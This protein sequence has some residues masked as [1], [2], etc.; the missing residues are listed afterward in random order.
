MLAARA[1]FLAIA[2]CALVPQTAFATTTSLEVFASWGNSSPGIRRNTSGTGPVVDTAADVSGGDLATASAS[3]DA[4]GLHV[5]ATAT[6][7]TPFFTAQASASAGLVNSFTIVPRAGFGGTH[8]LVRVPYSFSGSFLSHPSLAACAT[9]F[10]AV[11][12]RLSVDG[13][14][15][16]FYFVGAHSQGTMGNANF[17]AGGVAQAGMIEGLLPVNTPL[18]LRASLT[19][20]VHCQ[21]NTAS[22]CGIEALFGGALSYTGFSPD[23][24]DIVWGLVPTL[25]PEPASSALLAL[26][27]LGLGVAGC[28]AR[29]RR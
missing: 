13:L 14:G 12:V 20:N 17:I 1:G 22:S 5:V 28:F 25:V 21:S 10:G 4:F 7:A 27:L 8:A 18:F 6:S 9:C 23:E 16:G 26:G 29:P 24:V 15:A 3:V 19:T 11:D 2:L